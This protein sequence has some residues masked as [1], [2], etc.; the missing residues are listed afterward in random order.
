MKQVIQTLKSGEISIND[1]PIPSIKESYVL[2]RN[3]H[4]VISSG[5]EKTKIDMGK[6]NLIEKA[7]ARPDLFKQ[8]IKKLKTDGLIKTINTVKSRLESPSPLGYSCSGEVVSV[9]GLVDGIKVGDRVACAGA[10]FA[11]HAEFVSVPK[12]LVVKIPDN[13]SSEEAAFTT[14]GSIALQGVRL[15]NPKIGETYLVIGMGLI[16]QIVSQILKSS[17]C[18]VVGLDIDKSL[19]SKAEKYGVIPTGYDDCETVCKAIT[20][21]NGVDGVIICAGT[22]S[23]ESINISGNVTREK[24]K[25]S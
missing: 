16:G 2:V 19:T 22:S 10:E 11:N 1:V 9:G 7:R 23:N 24:V 14:I 20:E 5:T 3:T 15:A 17:G 6:K 13:V 21:N 25:S 8:V 18:N 12:N 4:S